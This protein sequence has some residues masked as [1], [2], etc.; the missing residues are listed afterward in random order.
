MPTEE[1]GETRVRTDCLNFNVLLCVQIKKTNFNFG[2]KVLG[3]YILWDFRFCCSAR[4][5]KI[6]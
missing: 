5:H 1:T 2:T 4:L 6:S 3:L